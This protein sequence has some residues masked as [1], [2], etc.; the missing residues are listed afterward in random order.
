MLAKTVVQPVDA[1]FKSSKSERL[2]ED[3]VEPRDCALRVLG[4]VHGPVIVDVVDSVTAC[5]ALVKGDRLL[6]SYTCGRS[7]RTLLSLMRTG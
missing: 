1:F 5:P 4:V 2:C 3:R 7:R 6:D